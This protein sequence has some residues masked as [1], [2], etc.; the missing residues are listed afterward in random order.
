MTSTQK[1]RNHHTNSY[2]HLD[3]VVH[4]VCNTVAHP[5]PHH[6]FQAA[7]LQLSCHISTQ[8]TRPTTHIASM[9][10]NRTANFTR[11][12][13]SCFQSH[14]SRH[15]ID[16]ICQVSCRYVSHGPFARSHATISASDSLCLLSTPPLH[17][18]HLYLYMCT[19]VCVL[20]CV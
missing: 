3:I 12:S 6:A 9:W 18:S 13:Q 4:D 1:P 15:H 16:A 11:S 19:C 2:E 17:L 5:I 8:L 20:P 10:A 7:F 14:S